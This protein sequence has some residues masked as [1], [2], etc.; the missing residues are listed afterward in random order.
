[1]KNV[2]QLLLKNTIVWRGPG[3]GIETGQ[4]IAVQDGI[5]IDPSKLDPAGHCEIFNAGKLLLMPGLVNAHAHLYSALARGMPGPTDP[6]MAF[7]EILEYVW[8]RLDKAL[9]PEGIRMSALV[10]GIESIKSGVTSLFDH[11]ASPFSVEGSLSIIGDAMSALGLRA[12]LCYEVSDRDGVEIANQGIDENIA[13][14]KKTSSDQP[15]MLASHFGIHAMFTITDET[16]IKIK[17]CAG[18]MGIGI[19]LHL[20]E[21]AEDVK[22]SYEKH[23]LSPIERLKYNDL[24]I[25]GSLLVH[26]VHL[27]AV[28]FEELSLYPVT[29]IQNPQSNMNNA[30]GMLDIVAAHKAGVQLAMGNDGIGGAILP[31]L[32]CSIFA[33]HHQY[34]D[35]NAPPYSIPFEMLTVTNPHLASLAFNTKLGKIEPGY[36]ADFLL[37]D[38]NPPTPWTELNAM[39][40]FV[41]GLCD[42]FNVRHSWI[43]GNQSIE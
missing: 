32:R 34:K 29:L 40:H 18:S 25:P 17:D 33:G 14:F 16:L 2:K 6:P 1:M 38:C 4:D 35:P 36:A 9:D 12:D 8:W 10:G 43:A 28:D 23:N 11:H 26:G 24:L 30:V 31:E 5:F 21:G 15:R 19:H 20:A 37:V 22:E 13:W 7:S 39:G 27:T 3:Y 41:F 42:R